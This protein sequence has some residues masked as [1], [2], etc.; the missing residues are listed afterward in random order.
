MPRANT[1]LRCVGCGRFVSYD[2]IDQGR[3]TWGQE[4]PHI[5]DGVS[6][7]RDVLTCAKCKAA[8]DEPR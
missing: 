6:E 5:W 8:D 3:A 4:T 7:P 1:P 2:D